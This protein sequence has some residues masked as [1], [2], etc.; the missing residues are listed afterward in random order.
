MT[1]VLIRHHALMRATY[2]KW[3]MLILSTV[4]GPV[5]IPPLT[6]ARMLLS[7]LPLVNIEPDWPA[8]PR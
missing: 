1:W 3:V 4:I 2:L 6:V 5:P 7:R 8:I